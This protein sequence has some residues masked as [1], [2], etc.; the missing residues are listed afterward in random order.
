MAF[1]EGFSR[2]LRRPFPRLDRDRFFR[3]LLFERLEFADL[4]GE[5]LFQICQVGIFGFFPGFDNEPTFLD[6]RGIVV[7][8]LSSGW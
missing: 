1:S 3:K 4:V 8:L 2:L 5:F 7:G 6:F